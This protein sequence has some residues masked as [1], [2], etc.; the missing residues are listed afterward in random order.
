MIQRTGAEGGEEDRR[1][2]LLHHFRMIVRHLQ[3]HLLHLIQVGTVGDAEADYHAGHGVGERPVDQALGNERLVRDDHLFAIEVGNG[4]GANTDF[5]YRTGEGADSH[6]I[7]DAH[8]TFE[9]NNQAG[10]KVTEDLL[11][12]KTQTNRQRGRQ[13]LQFVPGDA[14]RP[15]YRHRPNG[16]N[17]IVKNG[18]DGVGS[19]LTHI[20]PRQDQHLQQPRQVAD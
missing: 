20:E 17:R 19:P 1:R 5:A 15:E 7:P 6:R 16:D 3:Q 12:T 13:P 8:R 2:W 4:G 9:Q 18:G 11:Q 10:D 14:Q